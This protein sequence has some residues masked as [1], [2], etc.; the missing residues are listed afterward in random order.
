MRL[1]FVLFAALLLC[2]RIGYAQATDT[3]RITLPTDCK[4]QALALIVAGNDDQAVAL[5]PDDDGA[6]RGTNPKP[7]EPKKLVASLHLGGARTYARKAVVKP[8][9]TRGHGYVGVIAFG[10]DEQRASNLK[11]TLNKM[12]PASYRRTMPPDPA[13]SDSFDI[14]LDEHGTFTTTKTIY[15]FGGLHCQLGIE[16]LLLNLMPSYD[17]PNLR[18]NKFYKES[19]T[20]QV[21]DSKEIEA[22]FC[23]HH[24]TTSKS[25]P[26]IP[27][28]GCDPIDVRVRI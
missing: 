21:V 5:T 26:S 18:L 25:P 14:P 11:I 24:V 10:C 27:P 15:G 1:R 16:E 12:L 6:F 9:K 8:D 2:V 13:S 3:F 17:A 20:K 4:H 23:A 28:N 7:L 19:K 22:A